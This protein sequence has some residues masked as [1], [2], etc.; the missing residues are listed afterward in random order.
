[1]KGKNAMPLCYRYDLET[2]CFVGAEEMVRDTR[3]SEVGGQDIWVL[4]AGCTKTPP[5]EAK[6]GFK[7]KWNGEKWYY[8]KDPKTTFEIGETITD[9]DMDEYTAAAQWCNE[10]GAMIEEIGEK[11]ENPRQFQIKKFEITTEELKA[12]IRSIRNQY[13]EQTDKFMLVD[14]PITDGEREQYK[15]YR[16]YLRDFTMA[17]NWWEAEPLTFEEWNKVTS[18]TQVDETE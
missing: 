7:I 1:M 15:A 4:P 10:N 11:G 6:E 9:E 18:D 5:P 12:Q 8:K 14:Y 3:E 17:E 16:S 13:L 2:L